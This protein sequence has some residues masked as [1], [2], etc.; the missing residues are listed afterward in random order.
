V[1]E[2]GRLFAAAGTG[3]TGSSPTGISQVVVTSV[4]NWRGEGLALIEK[5][6]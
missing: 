2:H 5:V 6:D 3:D 4:G 1:I